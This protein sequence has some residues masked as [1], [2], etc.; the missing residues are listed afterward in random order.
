MPGNNL[1]LQAVD[2]ERFTAAALFGLAGIEEGLQA[3]LQQEGQ[4]LTGMK[5]HC[6]VSCIGCGSFQYIAA[7]FAGVLTHDL[8][9][10]LCAIKTDL[11]LLDQL[12]F[13][14]KLF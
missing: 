4:V 12:H 11:H 5:Q 2:E 6:S 7:P 3:L 9:S 1:E 14:D 13:G 10:R 8:Q